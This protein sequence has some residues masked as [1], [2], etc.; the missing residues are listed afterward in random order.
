M[1]GLHCAGAGQNRPVVDLSFHAP[2]EF[3]GLELDHANGMPQCGAN[4]EN[5]WRNRENDFVIGT[6]DYLSVLAWYVPHSGAHFVRIALKRPDFVE[7]MP[8]GAALLQ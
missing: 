2:T 3:S 5:G 1:P 4:A 6:L 7:G 8:N